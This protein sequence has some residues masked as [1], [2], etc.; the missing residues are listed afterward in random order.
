MGG[1]TECYWPWPL[2]D[3]STWKILQ[4][5]GKEKESLKTERLPITPRTLRA[6]AIFPKMMRN[7]SKNKMVDPAQLISHQE[8]CW[9]LLYF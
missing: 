7:V 8:A 2:S 6:R 3:V 4:V 5:E 1:S 9:K